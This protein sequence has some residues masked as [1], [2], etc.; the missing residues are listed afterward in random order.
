MTESIFATDDE[1]GNGA[2]L[3]AEV[4][5][6]TFSPV[7][8]SAGEV[9]ARQ[10]EP[11]TGFHFLESGALDIVIASEE[12]LRLPVARLGPGSHFGEMSLLCGMPVSA[13][14]VAS[15]SSVLYRSTPEEFDLLVRQRPELV[16]YLARELAARL[17]RTN[18]QLAAQQ[19]RQAVL[20]KLLNSP[21]GLPFK[22]DLP[23]LGKRLMEVVA[24]AAD[25]TS[26]L[27]L[28][29][30]KGV[31]K[32]A[33][34][35]YI[36]SIGARQHKVVIMVGCRD[37]PRDKARSLLFGDAQPECV[38]RFA[39]HL[40]YVQA[41][42][43][44]T[45]ILANVDR[46][47]PEAQEDLA[48]FLTA[49]QISCRD[50]PVDV[51]VIATLDA[52]SEN[53][54]AESSLCKSLGQ[55]FDGSQLIRLRPLR[56]RRRDVVP[57]AQHIL[58]QE[59]Q[60]D[61]GAQKHLGESAKRRLLSYDFH[62]ENVEE[63]RQVVKLGAHL[64][65]SD[66][67]GA[68]HLF[69]GAGI[70]AEVPHIDLLHSV[71]LERVLKSRHFINI[72][73][74]LVAMAFSGILAACLL[75]PA[76]LIGKLANVMVWGVWWPALIGMSV[77]FGRVWCALCPMSTGAEIVQR[78]GNKG[79]SPAN[80]I[81]EIG[82]AMAL[83]GFAGIIW[84]EHIARMPTHP[85]S[86]A[87]L[88]IGLA[89]I[90][91]AMGWLYQRHTWCRYICPLGAMCAAFSTGACLRIGA[92]KE[93]CQGVCIGNECFKGSD[94]ANACP[95]F[96]H[97]MF[98][99]N[100]QHCKLC[101]ECIRSC[102]S[103]SARLVFQLPLRDIWQSSLMGMDAAAMVPMLGIVALVLAAVPWLNAPPHL[104]DLWFTLGILAAVAIG[105]GFRRLFRTIEKTESG[106]IFWVGRILYGYALSVAAALFAFHLSYLPQIHEFYMHVT[107]I[108]GD[109]LKVSVL[110]IMQGAAILAGG[111]LTSYAVWRLCHQETDPPLFKPL[112][113]FITLTLITV[114]YVVADFALLIYR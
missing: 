9:L 111:S 13:D 109:M 23:G 35:L 18:E 70:D 59:T 68:E 57:L 84:V 6:A 56:Q 67:I 99:G 34:A 12:G 85:R 98:L 93:V 100:G 81:K 63:L 114:S 82:P 1:S 64:A 75:L 10:G 3:L 78:V 95:M 88:L 86:T 87:V 40:G 60:L 62:F 24:D 97:L 113:T 74:A 17:K 50:V 90:A 33:L 46:L 80:R 54:C 25:S 22:S 55:I 77:L 42:D 38:N 31:G 43:R 104:S 37:L 73:K 28:T 14:V 66:N 41:A 19:Q 29:G 94:Q 5:L 16:E 76:S 52:R 106:R 102:P 71:R 69:F 11:G 47:P 15:E 32:K 53:V 65:D 89:V 30:E 72:A 27:L 101:L 91:G 108:N 21:S 39:E 107:G 110:H 103:Q 20:S 2:S 48:V 4:M 105:L 7:R 58:H 112:L 26:P 36:H 51:R 79:L 83:V 45:L 49:E 61:S 92:R 96:N 44:G 8:V